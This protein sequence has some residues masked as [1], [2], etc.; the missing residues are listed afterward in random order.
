MF[1]ALL[2]G[3]ILG[4]FSGLLP[5]IG[6]FVLLLLATPFILNYDPISLIVLY[7]SMVSISQYI[8]SIPAIL[9]G[10]PGEASSYPAVIES[11]NLK[12]AEEVSKAISGSAI[13]SFIGGLIVISFCYLFLDYLEWLKYFYSTKLFLSLLVISLTIICFISSNKIAINF[14]LVL[15]GLLIG[16]V[17]YTPTLNYSF[18]VFDNYYLY[19]GIPFIVVSVM[20]F[21]IPQMIQNLNLKTTTIRQFDSITFYIP[22]IFKSLFYSSVGFLGGL[23]PSLTTILS[24]YAAYFLS[25]FST[26]D[27]VNHIVA[28]E[29]ANN[30]GGFSQ[31][32]PLILFSIPLL[33]S[34]AYLLTLLDIKGFD[35]LSIDFSSFFLGL[36][37]YF[38]IVNFIGLLIAWPLAKRVVFIYRFDLKI[39]F[40]FLILLLLLIVFYLGYSAN[41]LVFYMLC[42]ITFIPLTYILRNVDTTPLIFSFLIHDMLIENSIRFI[43]LL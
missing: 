2:V 25:K 37:Y 34:E 5:G 10:I 24:S 8:G 28:S 36:S 27:P 21:A 35:V 31:V 29:T 9:F 26:T 19:G 38:V 4:L 40:L 17:G 32:L 15:V 39:I 33:S 20:L 16:L 6:N 11:K 13:G 12:S 41:S 43:K 14:T 18:L 7:I 23:F 42:L 1:E 30:S 22:N 3:I